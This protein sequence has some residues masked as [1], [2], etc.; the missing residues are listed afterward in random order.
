[1][2]RV[3][4]RRLERFADPILQR[5]W[6]GV[7]VDS[8]A[9]KSLLVR[10]VGLSAPRVHTV[11]NFIDE[12]YFAIPAPTSEHGPTRFL[13]AAH[14]SPVKG[15][16]VLLEALV[17]MG[18]PEALAQLLHVDLLGEGPLEPVVRQKVQE[19]DLGRIVTFH[20]RQPDYAEWLGRADVV[21]MPS[22]WEGFGMALAEGMA[23][24]LPVISCRVGG[25]AEVVIDGRT[26]ILGAVD[27]AA[28]LAAAMTRLATEPQ[29][30]RMMGRA[31]RASAR[32]RFSEDRVLRRL[33]VLYDR[34]AA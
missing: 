26:G 2:H 25:A 10:E 3:Y 5:G 24:G 9:V 23:A 29:A 28:A 19:L 15:H 6:D 31:G 8:E 33:Q 7:F 32:E 13:M 1:L 30:R 4:Y 27:D 22:R 18:P 12:R 14:F 16:D 21:V 20:G 34:L 17:R 11:P